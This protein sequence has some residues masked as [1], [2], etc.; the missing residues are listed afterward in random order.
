MKKRWTEEEVVEMLSMKK[1]GCS[2]QE[3]ADRLG[4]TVI[5]CRKKYTKLGVEE[6]RW[7]EEEKSILEQDW[8]RISI[9][10]IAQKVKRSKLAVRVKAERLGLGTYLANLKAL[11][12]SELAEMIGEKY[13][14]VY[15]WIKR[16]NFPARKRKV[17][18]KM[19]VYLV[20]PNEFWK[21]AKEHER[22]LDFDAISRNWIGPKPEWFK[23]RV[24][25]T[26]KQ[27][28][29]WTKEEEERLR[30]LLRFHK[31]DYERIA[32][33]LDR[34]AQSVEARI[35]ILGLKERPVR[36][37][38]RTWTKEEVSKLIEMRRD[39]CSWG[40]IAAELGRSSFAC[41]VKFRRGTEA[42]ALIQEWEKFKAKEVKKWIGT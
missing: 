33:E 30:Q 16:N 3:I 25:K 2:W 37:F 17:S 39:G 5:S 35:R 27:R 10:M 18:G 41:Q 23:E 34:T 42:E 28:R 6:R 1:K 9:D 14:T 15:N 11:T 21:W 24:G 19:V 36:A 12:V 26:R 13:S 20:Y 29:V 8:G 7:T 31:Y 40:K 32:K 4:R 22:L 38:F